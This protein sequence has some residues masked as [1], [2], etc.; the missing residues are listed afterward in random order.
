MWLQPSLSTLK[1]SS[2]SVG[3]ML[4]VPVLFGRIVYEYINSNHVVCGS[5][6]I[7]KFVK[8]SVRRGKNVSPD[9]KAMTL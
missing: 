9:S 3:Q 8:I 1:D 2:F 6:V 7:Y 4:D 5:K